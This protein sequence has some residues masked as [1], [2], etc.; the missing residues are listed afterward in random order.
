MS[1]KTDSD[2]LI[3]LFIQSPHSWPVDCTDMLRLFWITLPPS[4]FFV[5]SCRYLRPRSWPV[6]LLISHLLDFYPGLCTA[7]FTV[8]HAPSPQSRTAQPK[9]CSSLPPC[10]VCSQS[11]TQYL[12]VDTL[13]WWVP[14]LRA[15]ISRLQV[16]PQALPRHRSLSVL[17]CTCNM[18]HTSTST[19]C[20]SASPPVPGCL[21]HSCL[22]PSLVVPFVTSSW[23]PALFL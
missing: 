17:V 6:F 19:V 15:V 1:V 13:S 4:M 21:M 12:Q 3:F 20:S 9:Q 11:P 2:V 22:T 18:W 8:I 23:L 14:S 7:P 16:T 10:S 5:S